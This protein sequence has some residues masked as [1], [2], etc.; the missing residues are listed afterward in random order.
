MN[1]TITISECPGD[2]NVHLNQ[3]RCK[4][5]GTATGPLYWSDMSD[6]NPQLYCKIERNKIYYLNI[7]HSNDS[8]DYQSSGCVLYP[9]INFCGILMGIDEV[10]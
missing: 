9:N 3:A 7:V 6:A 5:S 8:P 2:F 10:N 1:T 4:S